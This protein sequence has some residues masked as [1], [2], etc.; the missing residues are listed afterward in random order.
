LRLKIS[1]KQRVP[2]GW[3]SGLDH[4][5]QII[6]GLAVGRSIHRKGPERQLWAFRLRSLPVLHLR[7]ISDSG[8]YPAIAGSDAVAMIALALFAMI[9]SSVQPGDD[10]G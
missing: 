5:N 10:R 4:A 3:T 9:V 7:C 8:N 1:T 2:P 6:G